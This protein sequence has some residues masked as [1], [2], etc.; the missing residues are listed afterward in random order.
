M[1]TKTLEAQLVINAQDKTASALDSVVKRVGGAVKS[2]DNFRKAQSR[3][4]EARSKFT[5]AQKSVEA[6][7]RAM[8]GTAKPTAAL[9]A[10]YKQAQRAVTQASRA[11]EEQKS[12]VLGAKHELEGY[13]VEVTRLGAEQARLKTQSAEATSALERQGKVAAREAAAAERRIVRRAEIGNIAALGGIYVA[14]EAEHLAKSSIETYREFDKERRFQKAVMGLTD[15]EQQSLVD[16]AIHGGATSKYNDIQWLEAQR[17]LAARG[18]KKDQILGLTPMGANLGQALDLTLPDAVKQMEGA[19]FGFKKNISTLDDAM[20]SARQTADIQTKAAK[21]SGMTPE[22]ITEAYKFGATPARMSGVSEQVLLAFAGVSK[23]ANMG[24]DESGVAFRALISAAQSPT[25]KAKEAMLANGLNYKNYQQSPDHIALDPF[26]AN[27]AA[28]YGVK[29]DKKSQ[30]GLGRIFSD[31]KLL[32]DP[33]LFAPAVVKFLKGS[34]GGNDAKSLKSIAGAANRYR[35]A[36]MNS[37]DVNRFIT[38]LMT[39]LAGNLQFANAVFGPKQGSRIATAL[40]D[41]DTFKHMIDELTNHSAGFSEKIATERMAG[42]D[43]A[44][45]RFEG[46]MKNVET[47]IGRSWDN[48]GKGGTLSALTNAAGAVTQRFAELDKTVLQV[49]SGFGTIAA[50][51]VGAKG[52]VSMGNLLTGGRMGGAALVSSVLPWFALATGTAV[53]AAAET[54]YAHD[55]PETL[56]PL[57]DTPGAGMFDGDLALGQAIMNQARQPQ[58]PQEMK[59]SV[60]VKPAEGFWA[61]VASIWVTPSDSRTVTT[62]T[63]SV[64]KSMPEAMPARGASGGW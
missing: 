40:G 59:I 23:K 10:A 9:T 16:Q 29:L 48:G 56:Q 52:A 64:G 18:L 62:S 12:A 60:E 21:I 31:Q 37:V 61:K 30:A 43:G 6:A 55:H 25:G 33:A 57:L 34:L 49:I 53:I 50:T 17:E 47:A 8:S 22:D 35:D 54:D 45:S 2:I 32:A 15:E 27:I 1:A 36:S 11:F 58:P 14:H 19:I 26:V 4:V 24:G 44:V 38:D 13:G 5:E 42:F 20:A 46:A 39:K 28:R 7:A 51:A 63:G 3:F 41:A